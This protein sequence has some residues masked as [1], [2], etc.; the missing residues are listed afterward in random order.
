[1]RAKNAL[2]K[3]GK[4][5][6]KSA[7]LEYLDNCK[8]FS[9]ELVIKLQYLQILLIIY[10]RLHNPPKNFLRTCSTSNYGRFFEI[11]F[12]EKLVFAEDEY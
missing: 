12:Y 10:I 8:L 2:A 4:N 1:M 7:K 9:L 3:I 6:K 11:F 5:W